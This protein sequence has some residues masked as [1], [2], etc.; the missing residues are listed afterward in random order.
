MKYAPGKFAKTFRKPHDIVLFPIFWRRAFTA[1]G[2]SPLGG[3][4][5]GHLSHSLDST[6][7]S[8]NLPK[9]KLSMLPISNSEDCYGHSDCLVPARVLPPPRPGAA[10]A[11]FLETSSASSLT[12]RSC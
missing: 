6:G 1:V 3:G 12:S 8:A 11:S 10:L 2:T 5:F 4:Q 7:D 9:R